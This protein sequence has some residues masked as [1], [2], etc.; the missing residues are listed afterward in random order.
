M[1]NI[2]TSDVILTSVANID[3]NFDDLQTQVNAKAN[4]THSHPITDV[5]NLSTSLA[6]K[7]DALPTIVGQAL[8]VLR[9]N[10]GATGLEWSTVS[11]GASQWTDVGGGINYSGGAVGINQA[12]PAAPLDVNGEVRLVPRALTATP[13]NGL[14]FY[15]NSSNRF[16]FYQNGAW[17]DY[18]SL[19]HAHAAADIASGTMADARI[20]AS[21]VTQHQAALTVG[22]SQVTGLQAAIDAKE[23]SLPSRTSQEGKYL[24]V[25]AGGAWELASASGGASQWTDVTGGM[26]YA[27]KI[28]VG[29][30][31]TPSYTVDVAGS[32]RLVASS[33]PTAANGVIYYDSTENAFKAYQ[34]GNWRDVIGG[35]VIFCSP[36]SPVAAGVSARYYGP[37]GFG[38]VANATLN[39]RCWYTPRPGV[40]K[41]L[42]VDMGAST[43]ST[44]YDIKFTVMLNGNPTS[45]EIV[46][47]SGA[48]STGGLSDLVDSFT[49]AAGDQI[50]FRAIG[51]NASQTASA[52]ILAFSYEFI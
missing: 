32:V 41:N 18:A 8:K 28:S 37:S 46:W 25:S 38:G 20:A 51:T 31:N 2:A 21:N 22:I 13:T 27:Q 36:I 9:V 4:A 33:Q 43:N 39:Q 40:I 3:T 17:T 42:R 15:S 23:P 19:V 12:T 16:R 45:L 5:T 10:T 44:G 34:N 14:F 24:R 1:I 11:G 6:A 35:M 48:G 29:S 50:A 7:Q 49:V 52:N 47:A 26:Y 30:T